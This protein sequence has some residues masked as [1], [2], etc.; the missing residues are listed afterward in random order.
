ME[1]RGRDRITAVEEEKQ[2]RE[3]GRRETQAELIKNKGMEDTQDEGRT[4]LLKK[5]VRREAKEGISKL[6]DKSLNKETN[7]DKG[8]KQHQNYISQ[9]NQINKENIYKNVTHEKRIDSIAKKMGED[10]SSTRPSVSAF[11][12]S[13][14]EDSS[15]D[16]VQCKA[17][18][19]GHVFPANTTTRV[20]VHRG[21]KSIHLSSTPALYNFVFFP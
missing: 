5:T 9:Q 20:K 7:T 15:I 6:D 2:I 3:E 13:I 19:R 1:G 14:E 12:R 21:S 16:K 8:E 10:S 4:E 11:S 18:S 17:G